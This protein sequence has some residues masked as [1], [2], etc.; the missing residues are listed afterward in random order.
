MFVCFSVHFSIYILKGNKNKR[1]VLNSY[2]FSNVE[3]LSELFNC[4][5]FQIVMTQEG[6]SRKSIYTLGKKIHPKK[7]DKY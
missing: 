5:N 3:S 2:I 1:T 7:E 4:Q 6:E